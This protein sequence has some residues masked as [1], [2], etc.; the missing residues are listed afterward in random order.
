MIGYYKNIMAWDVDLKDG[1]Q[2]LEC[3]GPNLYYW[4]D[5]GKLMQWLKKT[6]IG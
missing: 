3:L 5:D 6:P 4:K 2:L 1:P